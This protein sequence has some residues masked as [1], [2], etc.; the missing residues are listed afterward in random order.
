MKENFPSKWKLWKSIMSILI[1]F[2]TYLYVTILY[3]I[4]VMPKETCG[5]TV[6]Y[7]ISVRKFCNSTIMLNVVSGYQL[8][9]TSD[10]IQNRLKRP[11]QFL[12]KDTSTIEAKTAA[13]LFRKGSRDE[14]RWLLRSPTSLLTTWLFAFLNK[15]LQIYVYSKCLTSDTYFVCY[16]NKPVTMKCFIPIQLI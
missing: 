2:L 15:Y 16:K 14:F 7:C 10:P 6:V 13:S 11:L 1:V 8:E 12:L 4:A 3:L 5:K 9:L